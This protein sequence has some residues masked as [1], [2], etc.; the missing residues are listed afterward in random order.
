MTLLTLTALAL[1]GADPTLG[2]SY[3]LVR[4]E[5]EAIPRVPLA[6]P[7]GSR[8]VQVSSSPR[9]AT[10][11]VDEASSSSGA[12]AGRAVMALVFGVLGAGVATVVGGLVGFGLGAAAGGAW[13]GLAVGMVVGPLMS[14]VGAAIGIALGAALFSNDV[15]AMFKRSVGWAFAAVGVACL[16]GVA[17]VLL[18]PGVFIFHGIVAAAAAA[19]VG[20]VVVPFIVE[21][22]RLA[23][24]AEAKEHSAVPVMTF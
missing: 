19:G 21:A 14:V 3:P 24:A 23:V 12:M 17:L 18:V 11:L 4:A 16:V 7:A 20:A 22:R 10:L 8:D 1:L 13:A 9:Q 2:L 15:G 6:P 5:P